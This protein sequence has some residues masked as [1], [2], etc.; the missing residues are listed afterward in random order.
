HYNW[1]RYYDP[2]SG[3]YITSDPIGL[4]G[5]L[6]TYAYALANPVSF[7]DPDGLEVRFI[8]R[9]LAGFARYTGKQHCFV[10]VSCPEE[11]WSTTLSLFSTGTNLAGWPNA[12]AKHR[13][14]PRDDPSGSNFF[15]ES[16]TGDF[17][18]KDDCEYEKAVLARYNSFPEG[19]VPY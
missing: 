12:G 13:D 17:C 14:D 11:G 1:N 7:F 3:R 6:N 8:C 9:S 15:D 5:G 2:S 10:H 19:N 4:I 16:V 18:S